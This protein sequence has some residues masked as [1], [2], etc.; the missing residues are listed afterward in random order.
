MSFVEDSFSFSFT[1]LRVAAMGS[2][3]E[4]TSNSTFLSFCVVDRFTFT[5][6]R[7]A[8]TGLCGLVHLLSLLVSFYFHFHFFEGSSQWLVWRQT[9]QLP[10][11]RLVTSRQPR[12]HYKFAHHYH[13]H[14][15]DDD[16]GGGGDG[17][18]DIWGGGG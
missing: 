2:C 9:G 17:D 3:V 18:I 1:F 14:D 4:D 8:A 11:C 12:S 16:D 13:R 15:G 7:G 6:L 5:F 10:R